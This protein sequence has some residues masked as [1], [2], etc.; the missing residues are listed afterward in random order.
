M[1]RLTAATALVTALLL[2]Q[3]APA[4]AQKSGPSR[5]YR[6]KEGIVKLTH[7]NATLNRSWALKNGVKVNQQTTYIKGQ[8]FSTARTFTSAKGNTTRTYNSNTS[9]S[10][11]KTRGL[12]NG[13]TAT[14]RTFQS[15]VSPYAFTTREVK[16]KNG[17]MTRTTRYGSGTTLK[18][19]QW[20]TP[21]STL[22]VSTIRDGNG[23][24]SWLR[25]FGGGLS[26]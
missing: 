5:W 22:G 23:K 8:K 14:W 24:L 2:A 6:V 25:R 10:V 20:A 7:A 18:T 11:E 3:A 4:Q 26:R 12:N 19:K 9:R 21:T 17:G 16:G 15:K 1:R 13:T